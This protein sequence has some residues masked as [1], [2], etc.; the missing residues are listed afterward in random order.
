[1]RSMVE[2]GQRHAQGHRAESEDRC[3]PARTKAAVGSEPARGFALAPAAHPTPRAEVSQAASD[4]NICAGLLL[5]RRTSC[6]RSGWRGAWEQGTPGSRFRRDAWLSACR[7]RDTPHSGKTGFA[8][9]RYCGRSRS[10]VPHWRAFPS[11]IRLRRTVPLPDTSSGR[12]ECAALTRTPWCVD[13]QAMLLIFHVPASRTRPKWST[14]QWW[15]LP[16]MRKV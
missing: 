9:C 8:G 7:D 5:Q 4:W 13:D 6:D 3:Y 15:S 1:M 10:W 11:T 14:P 12:I 2:G 16:S